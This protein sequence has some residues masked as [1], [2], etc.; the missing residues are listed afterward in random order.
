MS[1][2]QAIY[3]RTSFNLSLSSNVRW[4]NLDSYENVNAL[5]GIA[6]N[7][8]PVA[9]AFEHVRSQVH[10]GRTIVYEVTG[11]E[12]IYQNYVPNGLFWLDIA[13]NER[14][15]TQAKMG[16]VF[17]LTCSA[18]ET[19]SKSL[20]PSL[21]QWMS[22]TFEEHVFSSV[23]PRAELWIDSVSGYEL[24]DTA[25]SAEAVEESACIIEVTLHPG[26]RLIIDSDSY[27]VLLNGENIIET[28][29][30]S[31]FDELDRNTTAFSIRASEGTENLTGR[32]LFTERF[33]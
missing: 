27:L 26:D 5:A 23:D 25:A 28:H 11:G 9:I 31:W 18:F 16:Q 33:L 12:Q 21:N 7:F 29:H 1:Y 4:L 10:G 24:V 19:V 20:K 17:L 13:A 15:L 22:V 30:G 8:Y 6:T 32:V 14:I 3:N 2:N